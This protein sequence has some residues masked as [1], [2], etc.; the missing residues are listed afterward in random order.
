MSDDAAWF[1]HAAVDSDEGKGPYSTEEMED[2][3]RHE[4]VGER[5][6]ISSLKYTKGKIVEARRIARFFNIISGIAESTAVSVSTSD[7]PLGT[8]MVSARREADS[9]GGIG[10]FMA[11][12]QDPSLIIKLVERVDGICTRDETPLYMAVQQKPV[13]NVSPDAIVLTNRRVII[14]RQKIL[15]RLEFVDV[16]W[17][18]IRDVHFREDLMGA[19]ISVSGLNGHVEQISHLPK[20]Q[21]RKVYRLAQEM[22]EKMVE[23]RRDREIEVLRAGAT[24]VTVNND[25]GGAVAAA[26]AP[27]NDL[28]DPVA[29][30]KKLKQLLEAGLI[31]TSEYDAKKREV[32]ERL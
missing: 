12:G 13:V 14:F 4:Y 19:T 5:T 6:R 3:V 25:L 20:P 18:Q 22:E 23:A 16:T 27:G 9:I 28:S 31:E 30:L 1:V 2:L 21:A 24:Q 7:A 26:N 29:V 15:G 17:L 8:P 32:L 11:D 10:R